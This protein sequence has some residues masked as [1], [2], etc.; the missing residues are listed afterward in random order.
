MSGDE[1]R[2]TAGINPPPRCG[3][4][5][6]VG[7]TG[8]TVKVVVCE[9]VGEAAITVWVGSEVWVAGSGVAV[10]T[11]KGAWVAVLEHARCING[12]DGLL[13]IMSIGLLTIKRSITRQGDNHHGQ[14]G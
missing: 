14:N 3:S 9:G 6:T 7:V 13:Q 8:V 1:L 10:T 4:A 11:T 2:Y 12:S 5:F